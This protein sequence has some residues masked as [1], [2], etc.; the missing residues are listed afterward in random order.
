MYRSSY[1]SLDTPALLIDY[2]VMLKNIQNMQQKAN[3]LGVTL[4]PHTKTHK[5]PELAQ[6]Q[7]GAG[8]CGITV[9]KVGEAEVMAANGLADIFIANQIVGL[10]K[11]QRIRDLSRTIKIRLGVD[12]EFQVDQLEQ[13]F[14]AEERPIE[15]LIEVEVGEDRCGVITDGQLVHLTKHIQSKRMVK[16]VGVFSHE[17]H[18]YAA[19]DVAECVRLAQESQ[20]RTLRAA[21]IIRELGISIDTVSIGATPSL[22]HAEVRE[23]ITE[24][25]PGTYILMDAGQGGAIASY[26]SCAATVLATV[27]SKP[28]DTRVVLDAGAKALTAQ[29]RGAGICHTP[30]NGLIKGPNMVRLSRVYD[31]HGL[32][33]H[34]EFSEQIEVGDKIEIIP[35]HICPTSNL[36]DKAYLV[37]AGSTLRE[38]PILGRGKLR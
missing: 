19:K 3:R 29:N 8:A 22:M 14:I 33:Y 28:T 34:Q 30:G 10:S 21:N 38:I 31:E 23:G 20:V 1:S 35:N 37:S 15:V 36:Y 5:M 26:D 4:R 32:I 7:V 18:T 17:G 11:L 13:V 24:I 12:N 9:A 16:L 25:R 2:D 27:I 6:L